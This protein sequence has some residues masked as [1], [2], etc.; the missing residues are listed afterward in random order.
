MHPR[1]ITLVAALLTIALLTEEYSDLF[2]LKTFIG[3]LDIWD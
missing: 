2:E 1:L 3:L